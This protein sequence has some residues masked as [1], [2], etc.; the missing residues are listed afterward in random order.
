MSAA[1]EKFWK[2]QDVV[3][4]LVS[5]LDA[6]TASNLAAV[7]PLTAKVLEAGPVWRK[8]VRRTCINNS[9]MS[10]GYPYSSRMWYRHAYQEQKSEVESLVKILQKMKDPRLSILELLDTICERCP[11]LQEARGGRTVFIQVRCP[12][13]ISHLVSPLGFLLLEEVEQAFGSAKQEIEEP[14]S[15]S[16]SITSYLLSAQEFFVSRV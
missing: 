3:E 14:Q 8:L 15:I 7:H 12:Q 4:H 13:H 10:V 11:P 6:Q 16:W 1:E 2:T 5:F 9:T